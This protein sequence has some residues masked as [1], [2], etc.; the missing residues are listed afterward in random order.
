MHRGLS[1]TAIPRPGLGEG[2]GGDATA[3]NEEVGC[4]A[5]PTKMQYLHAAEKARA[6]GRVLHALDHVPYAAAA[7][8][9]SMKRVVGGMHE[10]GGG[11]G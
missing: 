10:E 8:T 2:G 4:T 6:A 9:R 3:A 1:T 7:S 5:H 11:P